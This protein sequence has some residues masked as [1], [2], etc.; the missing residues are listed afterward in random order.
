MC[1]I[2]ITHSEELMTAS[3]VF[4]S[5]A[6]VLSLLSFGESRERAQLRSVGRDSCTKTTVVADSSLITFRAAVP[7]RASV[8]QPIPITLTLTNHRDSTVAFVFGSLHGGLPGMRFNILITRVSDGARVWS[9]LGDLVAWLD[10]RVVDTLAAHHSVVLADSWTQKTTHGEVVPPGTYCV[11][12]VIDV[13]PDDGR[14]HKRGL[15]SDPASLTI[16]AEDE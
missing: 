12:G 5:G 4:L 9:R 1:I 15:T 11:R 8:G 7:P 14:P 10:I 13:T 6:V 16:V 2:W 3:I